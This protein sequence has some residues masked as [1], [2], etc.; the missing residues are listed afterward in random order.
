MKRLINIIFSLIFCLASFIKAQA[1]SQPLMYGNGMPI[2]E[3]DY[4]NVVGS[5]YL[6]DEW[7]TGSVALNNGKLFDSLLLKYNVKDDDVYFKNADDS[8]MAFKDGVRSFTLI[9]DNKK[10]HIFRNGYANAP[11]ITDRSYLEIIA[12][13]KVQFLKKESKSIVDT[14]EYGSGVT[15]RR[16]MQS[17]KYYLY[18]DPEDKT[19]KGKMILVKKDQK[20]I[21]NALKDKEE[22]LIDYIQKNALNLKNEEDIVKTINYYN[23]LTK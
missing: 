2:K 1:Q 9:D 21:L 5:P 15:E 13:G 23:T 3:F 22:E 19:G 20:S 18:I 14:K 12:A 8:P 4:T 16:F 7:H 10:S 17:A 11:G 6:F